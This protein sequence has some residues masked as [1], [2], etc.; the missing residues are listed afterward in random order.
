MIEFF[1]SGGTVI[2]Q[3]ALR[4]RDQSTIRNHPKST[5]RHHHP[6]PPP[7]ANLQ[8]NVNTQALTYSVCCSRSA[9]PST[10]LRFRPTTPSSISHESN[11]P[12]LPESR[13][14][15]RSTKQP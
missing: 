4:N 2:D 10:A 15:S 7:Q 1:A 5:T 6:K 14:S 13:P 12:C 11:R 9:S 3:D 8:T